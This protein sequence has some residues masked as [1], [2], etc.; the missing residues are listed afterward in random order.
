MITKETFKKW[1]A[2][3]GTVTLLGAAD[4]DKIVT[5]V[6]MANVAY[7]I[8]AQPSVPSRISV[9]QT[10]VGTA[11][12]SGIITV[13]GTVNGVTTSEV[14]TPVAGSVVYGLKYFSAVASVTGSGWAAVSTNDTITIGVSMEGFIYTN[15]QSIW[16]KDIAGNMFIE[17]IGVATATDFPMVTGEEQELVA[18][19]GISFIADSSGATLKYIIYEA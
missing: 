6:N 19:S 11:D 2:F 13:V 9:S 18:S 17:P 16:I 4:V 7:T 14:I 1:K 3:S 8:A 15:G 5:T 12:T 10:A